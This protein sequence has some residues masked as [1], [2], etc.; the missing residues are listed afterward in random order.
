MKQRARTVEEK[1]AR[2]QKLL[3]SARI[4]FPKQGYAKTTVEM[5]TEGAGLA[6][7][8][9]YLYFK[10]KA[11]IYRELTIEGI[12]ILGDMLREALPRSG[13]AGKTK[14]TVV[15]DTY[16]R[17]YLEHQ[18]YYSIIS[19]LHLGQEDFPRDRAM[20]RSVE[21]AMAGLTGL[22]ESVLKEGIASGE[23]LPLDTARATVSLWGLMDGLFLLHQRNVM[24]IMGIPIEDTVREGL[25]IAFNGLLKVRDPNP[26]LV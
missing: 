19:Y 11:A 22:I 1:E 23:F 5:I 10:S 4:I 6:T 21:S 25:R 14:L 2:K 3:N 18:D 12:R 8:T 16:F 17:F 26:G 15:A 9:F 24:G 13:T 20:L 7:G